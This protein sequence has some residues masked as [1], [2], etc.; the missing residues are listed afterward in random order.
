MYIKHEH[1]HLTLWKTLLG[2]IQILQIF[3]SCVLCIKLVKKYYESNA[4]ISET[5]KSCWVAAD[6]LWSDPAPGVTLVTA[7][8]SEGA[9]QDS[10]TSS[11]SGSVTISSQHSELV[12]TVVMLLVS[13]L[14]VLGLVA[15]QDTREDGLCGPGHQAP[16]GRD[17]QCEHM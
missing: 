1:G 14:S 7:H 16:S 5:V 3:I 6:R 13:L 10:R 17:A 9:G 4:P 2:R 15:G 11:A 8:W 12:R